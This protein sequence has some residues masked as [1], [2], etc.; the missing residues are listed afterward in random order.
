M[1]LASRGPGLLLHAPPLPDKQCGANLSGYL[2]FLSSVGFMDLSAQT[3]ERMRTNQL[4]RFCRMSDTG[5]PNIPTAAHAELV[6]VQED[7]SFLPLQLSGNDEPASTPF[8]E[9]RNHRRSLWQTL[10]P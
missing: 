7:R 6:R 3:A 10:K 9:K 1:A 8:A 5:I 4:R 2:H